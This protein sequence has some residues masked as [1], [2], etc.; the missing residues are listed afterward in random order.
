ML[1]AFVPCADEVWRLQRADTPAAKLFQAFCEDGHYGGRT[2]PTPTR[3]GIYVVTPTGTLL[4]SWNSRR[5]EYVEQ[6]LREALARWDELEREERLPSEALRAG[7]RAEDRYPMDGLVLQVFTR[8]LPR[9]SGPSCSGWRADAWNTDHL[10]LTAD[11]ARALAA[12]ELPRA[13][14]E[15]LVRIHGRDN[16]RG[17]S[18][19]YEKGDVTAARLVARTVGRTE[20]GRELLLE[21]EGAVRQ[22][23]VWQIDDRRDEPAEHSRSFGGSMV[24][25]ASWDGERFTSFE[26]A[27][28]GP[29]TGATKYNGRADDLGPAPM[30]VVFRLAPEA[31]RVAPSFFWAYGW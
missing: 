22:K 12:G 14:L 30:A 21:G 18:R 23:G 5:P 1:D 10:W 8:D 31:D 25:R 6:K 28:A 3:Q 16:V 2:K 20:D 27:W 9:D 11:E 15:R 29:R 26:L 7:P 13:A 17:Q 19:V 4:A 24:G